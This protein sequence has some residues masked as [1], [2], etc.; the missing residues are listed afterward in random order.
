MAD[1]VNFYSASYS[2]IQSYIDSG[3]IGATSYVLC[4]DDVHKNELIFVDKNLE[5]QPVV[6]YEQN[7]IL[8][9]D[10]LPT[11]GYRTNAFY[12]CNNVGYLYVNGIPVPMFKELSDDESTNDYDLLSNLPIVNKHGEVGNPVVLCDLDNGSYSVNGQYQIGGNLT[13]TYVPSKNVI[14]LIDSDDEYKYITKL[15]AKNVCAYKVELISMEVVT[16]KYVTESWVLEQ[17]YTTKTYVD[18]AIEAL[19]KKIASEM[20][21]ITKMSQ[22]ENDMGYLTN[23]DLREVSDESIAGLFLI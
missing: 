6:G 9:V 22:L 5:M 4:K 7:N 20:V 14:I 19:Y 18:E 15:D 21:T 1:A 16:D 17:G 13:T 8:F 12:V 23:D 11:E 10:K 3:V 2:K